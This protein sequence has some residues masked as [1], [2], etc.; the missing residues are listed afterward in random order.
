MWADDKH[1]DGDMCAVV[2]PGV[3]G[4]GLQLHSSAITATPTPSQRLCPLPP[5]VTVLSGL[6]A[7]L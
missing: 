5:P 7:A 2:S 6:G 4:A 1:A 3:G